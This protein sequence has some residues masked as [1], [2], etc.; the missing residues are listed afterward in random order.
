MRTLL[1]F[2]LKYEFNETEHGA[3]LRGQCREMA[4]H[5]EAASSNNSLSDTDSNNL[6]FMVAGTSRHPKA[7]GRGREDFSGG[8]SQGSE[9]LLSTNHV[10]HT[11]RYTVRWGGVCV[12]RLCTQ[13]VGCL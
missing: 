12:E 7:R 8:Q 3:R 2:L 11:N 13:T 1:P 4:S 6:T 5:R 9:E 10:R